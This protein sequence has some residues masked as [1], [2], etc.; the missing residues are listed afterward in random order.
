[1]D[2]VTL[3]EVSRFNYFVSQQ[4]PNT[5]IFADS[6]FG[7]NAAIYWKDLGGRYLGC[8]EASHNAIRTQALLQ[9]L[10]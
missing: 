6:F 1:M 2:N 10:C 7:D 5:R 3:N 9:G 4:E 8:N